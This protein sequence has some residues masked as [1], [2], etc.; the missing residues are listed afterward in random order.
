[1]PMKMG[2]RELSDAEILRM[3]RDAEARVRE[4]QERAGYTVRQDRHDGA[5]QDS[6]SRNWNHWN[7]ARRGGG[8]RAYSRDTPHKSVGEE[9]R[10]SRPDQERAFRPE[11]ERP[12]GEPAP[13]SQGT[14]LEDI[15]GVLGLD[16]DYLL[17]LGLMLILINDSVIIALSEKT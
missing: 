9:D 3:Q 17:I 14:I 11:H 12:R 4:M 6:G 8:R 2:Q 16:D 10:Q 1:M 15:M 13:Q 7:G 5:D